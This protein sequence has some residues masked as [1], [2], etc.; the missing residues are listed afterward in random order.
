MDNLFGD[1]A[2]IVTDIE[3][4]EEDESQPEGVDDGIVL[5][6][7]ETPDLIGQSRAESIILADYN[8]GRM[9]HA[10]I[11]GGAP[12][13]GK[14]T[15]AY[16]IARFL[17]SQ[18]DQ[19]P[20]LFGAPAAPETLAIAADH[21]VFRRVASG[22]HADLL[23]VERE[24]DEKKGRLKN[25]ISVES[26]RR[27]A[28]FLRKTA[29]EGG[30]RVVIVDGADCLN[31]SSQNAL[32]KIL[33]EPPPRALLILVTPQPGAF[34]PTIRS[35]CRT[36][37]LD[38]LSD[39]DMARFLGSAA[40]RLKGEEL[41]ALIRFA[42]GSPGRALSRHRGGGAALTADLMRML[43][44]LQNLDVARVH[45][46]A[47]K[48][49]R[50]GAEDDFDALRD[51]MTTICADRLRRAARDGGGDLGPL[52]EACDK[53]ERLFSQADSYHLDKRQTAL[54]AFLLL[55]NPAHQGPLI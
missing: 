27:I 23:T 44:D 3:E 17:L 22:G 29:A 45:D 24:M 42:E 51:L 19:G 30:W 46:L 31:A 28:P 15:L 2:D 53:M 9:P 4:I 39:A 38:P 25:D 43:G 48:I 34:L 40:P 36:V 35:R 41:S 16:R 11:L 14:A 1:D 6:P 32:L 21:P 55:R 50:A 33:E 12:G 26:V 37:L 13:V 7:R 54:H 10:I 52:I 20:G 18:E 5:P 49:G 47:D 8:A